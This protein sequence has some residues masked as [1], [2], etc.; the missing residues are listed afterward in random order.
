MTS[1]PNRDLDLKMAALMK[2]KISQTALER[3]AFITISREYGCDGMD[4]AWSL[5]EELN[6]KKQEVPWRLFDRESL[7]KI[8]SP[9]EIDHDML[10]V[11][12]KYGHSEFLG[13]L[14]EALFGKKS[15]YLV[16]QNMAK[17]MR[18]LA[19]RGNVIFLGR[20]G[21]VITKDIPGGFHFRI[22]APQEWR[23]RNHAKRHELEHDEA[24]ER[25]SKNQH[26]RESF[27]KTYLAQDIADANLYH[28]WMNNALVTKTQMRDM[29]LTLVNDYLG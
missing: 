5:A 13:Y 3:P 6:K 26:K 1:W 16:V 23:G 27:V 15:Q 25:V 7:V 24:H 29:V 4:L 10:D 14:Q 19:R 20:G 9:E 11:L 8:A 18:M 2:V 28:L 21:S 22:H 17:I 12:D